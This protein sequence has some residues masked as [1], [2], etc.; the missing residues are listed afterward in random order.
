MKQDCI[1]VSAVRET[2]VY[3]H[4]YWII[5]ILSLRLTRLLQLTKPRIDIQEVTWGNMDWI[6]LAQY[7]GRWRAHVPA[8]MNLRN[9]QNVKNFLTSRA[10]QEGLCSMEWVINCPEILHVF[11]QFLHLKPATVPPDS[12]HIRRPANRNQTFSS[13]NTHLDATKKKRG[14]K[15]ETSFQLTTF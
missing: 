1:S 5:T 3:L 8:V 9:P 10:S 14:H 15:T 11:P 12:E 7:W 2:C 6:H 4:Y 13:L